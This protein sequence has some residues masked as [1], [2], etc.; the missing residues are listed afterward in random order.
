[1]TDNIPDYEKARLAW[2]GRGAAHRGLLYAVDPPFDRHRGNAVIGQM[3]NALEHFLSSPD[4]EA[5]AH[6]RVHYLG[7]APDS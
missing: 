6:S 4:A 1:M 2:E 3:V 5:E 7:A